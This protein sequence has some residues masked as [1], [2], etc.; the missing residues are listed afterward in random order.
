MAYA[1]M[2]TTLARIASCFNMDLFETTKEDVT[3]HCER[4]LAYPKQPRFG[5]A[6]IGQVKVKVTGKRS[7]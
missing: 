6:A 3:V 5:T 4:V 7:V 2:Y 1:E